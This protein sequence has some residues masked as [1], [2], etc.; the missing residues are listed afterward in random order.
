MGRGP[1]ELQAQVLAADLCTGCGACLG[2]CPYLKTLGER[3]TFIHECPRAEGRCY[4]VCPRTEFDPNAMDWQVF[5]SPRRDDV[6]GCYDGLYFARSLDREVSTRGQYGG[7]TTALTLFALESGTADAALLTRGDP[8]RL[9]EPAIARD[10]AAVLA[11]A[12]TK[13]T[14]CPTLAPLA[15]RLRETGERF[16]VVGR[17]CQVEAARKIEAHAGGARLPLV[18]GIFCFWAL[19]PTF[20]RFLQRR[21]DLAR[22]TKIDMP[23][24]GGMTFEVHGRTATLP[25]EDV[26]PFIRPACQ[27]CFDPTAEWADVAVGSTEYDPAWNTLI[28]RSARG[29]ELVERARGAGAIETT[30]YPADRLPILKEAVQRKKLRVI[31]AHESGATTTAYLELTERERL[32]VRAWRRG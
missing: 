6:L 4:E 20:Y 3:V 23:K 18:M 7:V 30:P 32:A 11:A 24:E 10:R 15:E 2:H 22:A 31:D 28:V 27:S 19:A 26:R 29:R 21:S 17:P 13:Y 9:P 1:R 14:A 8:T 16:V 5:N 25:I 12:G